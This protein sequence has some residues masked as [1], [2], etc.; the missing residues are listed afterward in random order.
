MNNGQFLWWLTSALATDVRSFLGARFIGGIVSVQ[1][2]VWHPYRFDLKRPA[3]GNWRQ[4]LARDDGF[5]GL[6]CDHRRR[7]GLRA[8]KKSALAAQPGSD[9]GLP[10]RAQAIGLYLIDRLG[11][12]TLRFV[13]SIG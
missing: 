13:G 6:S 2:R 3:R 11:R 7:D 10:G 9:R 8:P 5:G 12:Q 4:C 1:H